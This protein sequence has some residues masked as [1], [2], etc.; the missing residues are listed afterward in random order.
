[1]PSEFHLLGPATLISLFVS[2]CDFRRSNALVRDSDPRA[3]RHAQFAPGAGRQGFRTKDRPAK[4]KRSGRP[5]SARVQG[6]YGVLLLHFRKLKNPPPLMVESR[7]SCRGVW[8]LFDFPIA[9][10]G[11]SAFALG[12]KY[13]AGMGERLPP[14]AQY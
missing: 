5:P 13:R 14:W 12:A 10:Q 3:Q 6:L 7:G 9:A 2:S 11:V 1:M 8:L 4:S